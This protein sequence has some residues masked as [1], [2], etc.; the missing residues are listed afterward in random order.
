D[1]LRHEQVKIRHERFVHH[2]LPDGPITSG[3]DDLDY[4]DLMNKVDKVVGEMPPQM[5]AVFTLSR[6]EG[7]RY[8]QISVRL[9]ISVKT[10]ETQISRALARLRPILSYFLAVTMAF[11]FMLAWNFF[12]NL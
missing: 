12:G 8:R 3:Y 11:L 9:G 6:Y 5:R 1:L 2:N 10:V 4:K 7:L